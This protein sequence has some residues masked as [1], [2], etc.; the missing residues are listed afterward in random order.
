[1]IVG[2]YAILSNCKIHDNDWIGIS[3]IGS[4]H[5]QI[6]DCELYNNLMAIYLIDSNENEIR[7]CLCYENSEDI[8]LFQNAHSNQIINCTCI[9]NDFSGIHVQ[10]S[11]GNQIMNCKIYNG[12]EGI[13]LAYAP[14]TIMEGNVLNNNNE[15]FGIGSSFLSDFYCDI[16]TSNIINGKPIYYWIDHYNEQVPADAAFIALISCKNILVK[17]L[18]I[19]NN[20]QGIVCAGSSNCTIENC[21]FRNNGG[22]GTFFISSPN[23]TISNCSCRNSFFSGIY[24]NSLSNRNIISNNTLSNIQSCGIWVEESTNS[25]LGNNVI[26]NCLKGISLDNSNNN[27]LRDNDMVNCGLFVD[28]NNLSDYINDV[29]T[30]NK[31]NGKTLYYYIAKNGLMVPNDAGEVILV[32]CEYCNISNLDCSDGTI[33]LELAYSSFNNISGNILNGNSL[34]SIDLDCSSNNHNIIKENSIQDNNYGIDVDISNF[35]IIQ[36]NTV[37]NNGVGFSLDSSNGNIVIE[38]S[39]QNSWN[40][41]YLSESS[42]N[43][44]NHNIIKDCD[45]NGVYLLYSKDN[46]VKENEMINC[47]LLVYGSSLFEYIND[48]DTSN[49]VNGKTLYY[50]I[51]DDYITVPGNAGEV[52]LVNCKYCNVSNLDCSDGTIGLELAYSNY[53]IISKNTLN[54]N[55]FAG[56]YLESSNYNTVKINK[57]QNNSYGITLQLA[58]SNNIKNNKVS[59]NTYGCYLYLSNSNIFSGNNIL[60]NTYGILLDIPCNSN[61]IHHN[62]LIDNGFNAWDENKNTNTWDDGKKGN[63]WGDY[64]KIY[65]NAKKMWLKGIWDTPYDIPIQDNQDR[66]PLIRP[67]ISSKEKTINLIGILRRANY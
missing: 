1:M 44:I 33:G 17:D 32:N 24:L 25:H 46:A 2:D 19:N 62:N 57:I 31:V 21:S 6:F 66:Y 58:N 5:S 10:Q 38:N 23:N 12:Y 47:G 11:S 16:D 27:V 7:D 15:N 48:V 61:N 29:D 64:T 22:H 65:P 35:N 50:Y 40:G 63:Y 37:H 18:E 14:N 43:N 34:V 51:N 4:S 28:G 41:I 59:I 26:S 56:L 3:M 45:F 9:G 60:Y 30:S 13:G 67:S 55:N 39:I 52:I 54:N 36:N 49:K 42:N 20:F 53:N 8:L